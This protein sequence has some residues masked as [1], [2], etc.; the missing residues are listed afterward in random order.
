MDKIQCINYINTSFILSIGHFLSRFIFPILGTN[1]PD[2][3]QFRSDLN[4]QVELLQMWL[5]FDNCES[6]FFNLHTFSIFHIH[7]SGCSKMGLIRREEK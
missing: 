4:E 7:G 3:C 5:Y 2:I 1:R 6:K